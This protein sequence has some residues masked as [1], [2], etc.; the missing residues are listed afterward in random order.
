MDSVASFLNGRSRHRSSVAEIKSSGTSSICQRLR[1]YLR[2]LHFA[3]EVEAVCHQSALFEVQI[4]FEL[5]AFQTLMHV[6][7]SDMSAL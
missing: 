3:R 2:V 7:H 5:V 4:L 1:E 6:L